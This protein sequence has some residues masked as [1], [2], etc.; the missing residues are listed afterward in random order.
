MRTATDVVGARYPFES[1]SHDLPKRL[2]PR[3]EVEVRVYPLD[4]FP[5]RICPYV[6]RVESPVPP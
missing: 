3:E 2:K 4:E 1:I 5:R 6:G